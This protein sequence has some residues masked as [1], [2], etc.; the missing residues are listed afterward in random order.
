MCFTVAGCFIGGGGGGGGD[1]GGDGGGG[2]D[3]GYDG[4]RLLVRVLQHF[5]IV[6]IF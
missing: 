1:G 3:V 4:A 5:V 2:G 6:T